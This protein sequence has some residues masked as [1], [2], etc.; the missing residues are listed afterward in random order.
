MEIPVKKNSYQ[1]NSLFSINFKM[2]QVL[3]TNTSFYGKI[4]LFNN[5]S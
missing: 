2:S 5:H 4:V 3:M 1:L